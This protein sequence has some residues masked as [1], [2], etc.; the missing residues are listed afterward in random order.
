M[1]GG[2]VTLKAV[3]KMFSSARGIMDWLSQCARI[4]ASQNR[5]VFWHT[6]LG[7]PCIQPYLDQVSPPFLLAPLP[8][9]Q[10]CLGKV[11]YKEG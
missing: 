6:P 4:V 5:P 10:A 2:Q 8:C 11:P 9:R 7:L 1:D 3:E